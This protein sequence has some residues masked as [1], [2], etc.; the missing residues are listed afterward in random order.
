ML[1]TGSPRPFRCPQVIREVDASFH[2]VRE[3]GR[4]TTRTVVAVAGAL[5]VAAY[6]AL[7]ALDQLVLDPLTLVPGRSLAAVYARVAAAGNGPML[8]VVGVLVIAGIGVALGIGVAVAGIRGAVPTSVVT[9]LHLGVLVLGGL[10][11][12]PATFLLGMDVLDSFAV[13][14]DHTPWLHVLWTTSLLALAAVPAVLFGEMVR[15][16]R[17]ARAAA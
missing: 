9:V 10:A 6:A 2:P 3:H 15:S 11:T 5:V 12:V 7:L 1:T 13:T 16:L 14:A 4:M 17:R 8:D